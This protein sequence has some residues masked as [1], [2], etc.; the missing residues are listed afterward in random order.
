LALTYDGRAVRS[1]VNGELDTSTPVEPAFRKVHDWPNT[2]FVIGSAATTPCIDWGD[3]YFD[4]LIDEV[5]VY[6]RALSTQNIRRLY[7]TDKRAQR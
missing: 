1:Y 6:S 7:D 3:Q 5:R 4:G 2:K